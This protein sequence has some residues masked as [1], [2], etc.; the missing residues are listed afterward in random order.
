MDD[1][2][3]RIVDVLNQ[4]A[5]IKNKTLSQLFGLTEPAILKRVRKLEDKKFIVRYD[6]LLSFEVFSCDKIVYL[7]NMTAESL[8]KIKNCKQVTSIIRITHKYEFFVLC[9]Y[10]NNLQRKSIESKF[11]SFVTYAFLTVQNTNQTVSGIPTKHL[12]KQTKYDGTFPDKD[13]VKIIKA[14]HE[15][16]ARK[17]VLELSAITKLSVDKVWYRKRKIMKSGMFIRHTAQPGNMP[18]LFYTYVLIQGDAHVGEFTSVRGVVLTYK[19]ASG[20]ALGC[21]V[22]GIDQY[23][24]L[25][26]TIY[27]TLRNRDC[28]IEVA[29]FREYIIL[30]RYPYEFLL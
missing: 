10:Q 22:N 24:A 12:V 30:N 16:G 19:T 21:V 15:G 29:I 1:L 20:I 13:D 28:G 5:C 27:E 14:M 4:D 2:D 26:Q 18:Q 8:E 7:C 9:F 3:M 25:I 11:A 23:F 6:S 17:T